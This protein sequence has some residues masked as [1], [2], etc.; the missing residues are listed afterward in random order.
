MQ[1]CTASLAPETNTHGPIRD[2]SGTCNTTTVTAVALP[3]AKHLQRLVPLCAESSQVL[4]QL[5]PEAPLSV[6]FGLC[7]G[8]TAQVFVAPTLEDEDGEG[9]G[10][11]PADMDDEAA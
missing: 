5:G 1:A 11:A 6:V 2:R 9:A 10:G 8:G 7:G 3:Q 4:L